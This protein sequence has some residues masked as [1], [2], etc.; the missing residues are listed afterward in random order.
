MIYADRL[1]PLWIIA[2]SIFVLGSCSSAAVGE[3]R[4]PNMVII[5]ADDLG[6]GDL[7]CYG[8]PTIRTPQIDGM[9]AAGMKFT[10]FYAV[11]SVCTPSR[12]ALL[13][14][15][16][17]IRSGMVGNRRG[18]LLAD[19]TLGLPPEEITIAT[20]LKGQGYATACIGKWHLG[21]RPAYLP[22]RHGFDYYYGIPYSNDM[23]PTPLMR[24]EE[25]IE[26]PAV[27]ETL[28]ARYTDEAIQF[29]ERSK[30][31]PFFLYFAHTFP[32]VPLFASPRFK[33]QSRRGSYGDVVEELDWS[34]GQVLRCLSE[35]GLAE[36]T[37]VC[38]TS[39]NGPW[40]QYELKG[41]SSGLLHEGKMTTWEGGM[42]VPAVAWWPGK[43]KPG[44]VNL[45]V[46]N[47]M[48]L[49]STALSLAG[50][51]LPTDRVIDGRDLSPVLFGREEL[52]DQPFFYYRNAILSAVRKGPWKMY[53][54]TVDSLGGQAGKLI[55]HNP[56]LLYHLEHDPSETF[57]V[58]AAHPEVLAALHKEIAEHQANLVPGTFMLDERET[59]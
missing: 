28:T 9:A 11:S 13:T 12:A 15:R 36:N 48:D 41:G 33:D 56:P 27:Q 8:H 38:F 30:D 47:T 21:H 34:V 20:A 53:L 26:E 57:N 46:A 24:N 32:H 49:F 42:R 50:V 4:P 51:D 40:L 19:S 10:Q 29:I 59:Q 37:L 22:T 43:I 52:E 35:L 17:P 55:E 25:V 6:Y 31:R 39:D 1:K 16:Y 44:E 45:T 14:G 3:Q 2:I 54:I 58:S 18:V 23:V 5:F 7:G